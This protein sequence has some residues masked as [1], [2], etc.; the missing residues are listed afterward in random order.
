[1][2]CGDEMNEPRSA[3]AVGKDFP[4]GEPTT[5][6]IEVA[7]DGAVTWGD[8]SGAYERV[9]AGKSR[10]F[11][12]WP[13][14]WSSHLFVIDDLDE[15]ARAVGIV[16]DEERTGLAQH[17]HDVSWSVSPYESKPQG[18]YITID[19]RLNCGCQ[20]HDLTSFALHMREQQGWDIATSRGWGKGGSD[21]GG[22]SYSMR[23]RRSSLTPLH[24]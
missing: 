11:A 4:Y 15:Y 10:L 16:H 5:C 21:E 20:I 14:K 7:E 1:M 17:R 19:V 18:A 6:F 13:G 3:S 9:L 24:S 2:K 8:G 23:V 12:V 22:Y